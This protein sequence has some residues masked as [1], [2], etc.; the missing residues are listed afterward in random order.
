MIWGNNQVK[1][2][3]GGMQLQRKLASLKTSRCLP[4]Q[5]IRAVHPQVMPGVSMGSCKPT[6][7]L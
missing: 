1:D 2:E 4:E 3:V 5:K 7:A 6:Q